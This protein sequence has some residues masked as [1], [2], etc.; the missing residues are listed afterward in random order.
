MRLYPDA[1]S[2]HFSEFNHCHDKMGRFDAEGRCGSDAK[3]DRAGFLQTL[4]T[5]PAQAA[6]N[7]FQTRTKA[8]QAI[9]QG[10]LDPSYLNNDARR[11]FSRDRAVTFVVPGDG[12]S[13]ASSLTRSIVIDPK[14][15]LSKD[16]NFGKPEVLSTLRHEMGHI[17]PDPIHVARVAGLDPLQLTD[18]ITNHEV[19]RLEKLNVRSGK[20]VFSSEQMDEARTEAQN[21]A[22]GRVARIMEEIRAWRNGIKIGHGKISWPAVR[23]SL[24]SYTNKFLGPKEGPKALDTA[25]THLQ[26]YARVVK[27]DYVQKFQT[28]G[29]TARASHGIV[30]ESPTVD[31]ARLKKAAR[32]L[33]DRA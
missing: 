32:A 18:L 14:Q 5:L 4:E 26:R 30:L 10:Q 16:Q 24:G 31:R 33:G 17:L 9:I 19:N 13:R 3:D 15:V 6:K 11:A 28:M 23:W 2:S 7:F 22:Y 29:K 8:K 25:I 12:T 27:R 1:E 20:S 21:Q